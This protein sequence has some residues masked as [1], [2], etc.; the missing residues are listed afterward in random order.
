MDGQQSGTPTSP[1][2]PS[3]LFEPVPLDPG[4]HGDFGDRAHGRSL[5]LWAT[6]HRLGLLATASAS[7][8]AGGAAAFLSR[9]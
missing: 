6:K 1:D 5:Q 3:N 7:A 8:V 4:A 9:R 2:R